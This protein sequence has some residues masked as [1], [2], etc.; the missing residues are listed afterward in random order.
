MAHDADA[1]RRQHRWLFRMSGKVGVK[2]AQKV[3]GDHAN[4]PLLDLWMRALAAYA[5]VG[6]STDEALAQA[7]VA[8]I[9][10]NNDYDRETGGIKLWQTS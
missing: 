5:K 7:R 9:L 8:R 3:L 10:R 6:Y 1:D 2:T 4:V